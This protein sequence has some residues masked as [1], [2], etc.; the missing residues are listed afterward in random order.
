LVA[1]I[2]GATL[3]RWLSSDALR[4][5]KHPSW[6]FPRDPNF[7]ELSS[8]NRGLPEPDPLTTDVLLRAG[9]KQKENDQDI[10]SPLPHQD[11]RFSRQG[12]CVKTLRFRRGKWK[13]RLEPERLP[14]SLRRNDGQEMRQV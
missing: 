1:E 6:I 10:G 2:S 14:H 4:P 13:L 8:L 12:Q 7:A 9:G 11:L 5:W 3:W